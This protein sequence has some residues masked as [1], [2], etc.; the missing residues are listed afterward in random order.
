MILSN[1]LFIL[2]SVE[3]L[4]T[5][6]VVVNFMHCLL[7]FMVIDSLKPDVNISWPTNPSKELNQDRKAII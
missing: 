1:A 2:S 5:Y 6:L 3:S 7:L 4:G